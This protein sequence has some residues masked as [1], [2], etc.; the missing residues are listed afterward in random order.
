MRTADSCRSKKRLNLPAIISRPPCPPRTYKKLYNYLSSALPASEATREPQTPSK[1][2]TAASA[3]TR[4]TPKTP[5]TGRRT[6]RGTKKPDALLIPD[7]VMPAIRKLAKAFDFPS[8][9]PHVF[10][11]VES[12]LPLLARI[13][14]ATT[15]SPSKQQQSRS[16]ATAT[17]LPDCRIKGLIA[18]TFL[19]VFTRMKNVEVVP[20]EYTVWR[21]T[22]MDTLLAVPTTEEIAYEDLS[23]E[24][25]ELMPMAKAEGW[26]DMEWFM[27]VDW[28]TMQAQWMGWR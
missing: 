9:A 6:P 25:E 24:A 10:T 1:R 14:T 28:K 19:Y 23:S 18:V 4:T 11:G 3:A 15:E 5:V 21:R 8:A 27:N 22:V 20:E 12:T 13:S 7:W 17:D 2:G 16:S 26:L